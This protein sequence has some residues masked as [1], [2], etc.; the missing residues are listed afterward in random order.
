MMRRLPPQQNNANVARERDERA[1]RRQ[2]ILL[3]GGLLLAGGFVFA[4]WQHF[5]AVQYGYGNETLRQEHARLLAEQQRLQLE[6]D[7][8]TAPAALELA[9]RQLGMQPARATQMAGARRNE[10][11]RA[12]QAGAALAGATVVDVLKR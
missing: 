6:L 12:A 7:E 8:A 9:A 2:L 3:A 10:T 4:I 5:A 11:E 1:D